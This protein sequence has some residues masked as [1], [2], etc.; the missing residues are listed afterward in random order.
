MA[1]LSTFTFSL[2]SKELETVIETAV[3]KAVNRMELKIK[4]SLEQRKSEVCKDKRI[5]AKV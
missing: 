2:T 3:E 5:C 1:E 4:S